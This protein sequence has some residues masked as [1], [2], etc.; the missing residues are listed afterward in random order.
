MR[1]RSALVLGAGLVL[2]G[3]LATVVPT[4]SAQV[5][6]SAGGSPSSTSRV[7]A[8]KAT[9]GAR[10]GA[11]AGRKAGAKAGARAGRLAG[12]QAGGERGARAGAIAGRKAGAL[13]GEKAGRRAGTRLSKAAAKR[14]GA[15][16]GAKAGRLAGTRAG[17]KAGQG[18]SCGVNTYAKP[19]GSQYA[20]V[21]GDD[22][23]GSTLDT[24]RWRVMSSE[25]FNFGTRNDCFMDSPRNVYVAD[26]VLNLVARRE[27]AEFWCPRGKGRYRTQYTSGLVSTYQKYVK[28]Y[29]RF[30]FRARFPYTPERGLQT[31]LWLWPDGATGATWPISGE[32]DVAEWYS[33]WPDR[34]IP[35]LHHAGLDGG[36]ST[37]NQCLV[38]R[39]QDWHT[40]V[41]EWQPRLIRISYDGKVCLE[42]TTA[43]SPFDKPY[44][45]SMFHAFGLLKNAPR[46][47]TPGYSRAQFAW[48]RVWD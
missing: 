4:A 48:V 15:K 36:K 22:F 19:D 7:A 20:C 47:T 21:F 35:Y 46:A 28:T 27:S 44:M 12:R 24:S 8:V 26:G 31:S 14:A 38:D 41:L 40:Y 45:I 34:V 16:A 11:T 42:N 33:Q 37:N 13:A 17:R 30:E 3:G 43:S 1:V 18:P 2:A 6:D 29:G 39:V 23:N 32:I 25:E 9:P 10:A 5:A